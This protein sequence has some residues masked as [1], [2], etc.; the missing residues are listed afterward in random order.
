MITGL[1]V[2]GFSVTLMEDEGP[3]NVQTVLISPNVVRLSG[4]KVGEIKPASIRPD[5]LV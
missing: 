1:I 4:T 2:P 3:A 5:P